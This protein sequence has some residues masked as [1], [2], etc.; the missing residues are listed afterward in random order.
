MKRTERKPTDTTVSTKS[1]PLPRELFPF[2]RKHLSLSL[3]RVESLP[4]ESVE[5]DSELVGQLGSSHEAIVDLE[6]KSQPD[7]KVLGNAD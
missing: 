7:I 4:R 1:G 2:T 5:E 6:F 3:I